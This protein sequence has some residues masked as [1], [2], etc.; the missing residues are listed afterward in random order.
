MFFSSQ[1]KS[2]WHDPLT[3]AAEQ[4]LPHRFFALRPLPAKFDTDSIMD[5]RDIFGNGLHAIPNNDLDTISPSS[6]PP[7]EHSSVSQGSVGTFNTMT[8]SPV[9]QLSPDLISAGSVSHIVP[10]SQ[11]VDEHVTKRRTTSGSSAKRHPH[12]CLPVVLGGKEKVKCTWPGCSSILKKDS[13]TRHVDNIHLRTV[14][15]ICARC[16]REFTRTYAKTNHEITC[17]GARSKRKR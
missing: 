3:H 11:S 15:A 6:A 1:D 13:H 5:L 7:Q 4:H 2:L 17:L 16:G 14:K 8:D 10:P 12:L 9:G